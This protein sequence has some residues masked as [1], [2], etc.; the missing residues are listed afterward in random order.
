MYALAVYQLATGD[1]HQAQI[2]GFTASSTNRQVALRVGLQHVFWRAVG[3]PPRRRSRAGR[4]PAAEGD[5]DFVRRAY[6]AAAEF[7]QA[8]HRHAQR[9]TNDAER[10]Y[11]H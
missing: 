2:T 1:A 10:S 7:F 11:R 8:L 9:R 3:G 5:R 4:R 6:S